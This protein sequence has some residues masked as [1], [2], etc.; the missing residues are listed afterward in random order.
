V[1]WTLAIGD[2]TS[3]GE[4]ASSRLSRYLLE[5]Q[6]TFVEDDIAVNMAQTCRKIRIV[7]GG[8]A[9]L[10]ASHNNRLSDGPLHGHVGVCPSL[11]IKL[12]QN[13][14]KQPKIHASRHG[15]IQA[16]ARTESRRSANLQIGIR[17]VKMRLLN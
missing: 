13:F 16:A 1:Q 15:E 6:A 8:V 11:G 4:V 12:R 2:V 17:A 14:P 5:A 3:Q 9:Q 10:G 7:S